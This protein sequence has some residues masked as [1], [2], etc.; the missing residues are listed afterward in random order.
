MA[1]TGTP[2]SQ[3]QS[4]L[5]VLRADGP[6]REH[7]PELMLFGRLVGAWD[8]ANSFFNEDGSVRKRQTGEWHFGWVLE[9][10]VIQDVI[11]APP[12]AERERTGAPASEYGT[13]IRAYDPRIAAWRVTFVAPVA[14][15]TV[16]LVARQKGDEIHL[17]GRSPHGTL[18]RWVF[19]D[20]EVD[21]FRWSGYESLD[22]GRTWSLGEVIEGRRRPSA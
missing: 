22:E 4:M 12:R 10:R 8:I 14:G 19:S 3:S 21:S 20:L 15:E 6:L 1:T 13:T 16:N 9:G 18:Y 17:E 2:T 5:E 11:L 7:E